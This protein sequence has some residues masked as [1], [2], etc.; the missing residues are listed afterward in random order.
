MN[1][2]EMSDYVIKH[3]SKET[4]FNKRDEYIIGNLSIQGFSRKNND[5]RKKKIKHFQMQIR[6]GGRK[7]RGRKLTLKRSIGQK[8]KKSKRKS[9]ANESDYFQRMILG[10]KL[11][12]SS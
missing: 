1:S 3:K 10:K 6:I 2:T 12:I 9:K 7:N 5:F 11:K 4:V 8:Q